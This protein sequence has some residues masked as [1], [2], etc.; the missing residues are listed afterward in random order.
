MSY[1]LESLIS[2]LFFL[3][4][5][6]TIRPIPITNDNL[7]YRYVL[8]EDIWRVLYLKY[9]DTLVIHLITN[10]YE[11]KQTIKEIENMTHLCINIGLEK[12]DKCKEHIVMKYMILPR[13]PYY[14]EVGK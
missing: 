11:L 5:I 7:L 2:F 14:I 6:T 1:L 4:I 13:I 10:S 9:G 12:E 3:L 8:L